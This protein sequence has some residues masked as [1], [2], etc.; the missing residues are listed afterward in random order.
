MDLMSYSN[1]QAIEQAKPLAEKLRPK[2]LNDLQGVQRLFQRNPWMKSFLEKKYLP[3]IILWG[4]P[5]TGKT[6]LALILAENSGQ[7]LISVNAVETGAKELKQ[8]G[9][10]CRE[11]LK[12]KG[13]RSV[14]FIDEIHRLN[15]SQQD[16]LLPFVEKGE[17]TLIGATTEN[18]SY[19]INR[20]LLSRCRLVVIERLTPADLLQILNQSIQYF[21]EKNHLNFQ[22][23]DSAKAAIVEFADGDA[24]RLLNVLEV[25][26][27]SAAPSITHPTARSAA[28]SAPHSAVAKA[29]NLSLDAKILKTSSSAE[30]SSA[31]NDLMIDPDLVHSEISKNEINNT[32]L[33]ESQ[34][35]DDLNEPTPCLVIDLEFVQHLLNDKTLA[36]DKN[37][38]QHYD[39]ISAFIKSLRGSDPDAAMYYFV[40]ML[41]GG[42]DPKFIA[43]RMV[44]FA[45]EDIGNADPRAITVAVSGFDALEKIGLPEAAINLAQVVTYLAT[46]PKSN[47]SYMAL[48]AAQEFVRQSGSQPVPLKLRSSQT[49]EMKNIGYGQGYK[50]PHDFPK[51]YVQNENY[52]PA[53]VSAQKFYE[54]KEAAYEKHI[55]EYLKWLKS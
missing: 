40:R 9:E 47:R 13:R 27:A 52:W 19:E 34:I 6:S 16:V 33:P 23:Q 15:K 39:I 50:Y 35:G 14:L 21:S 10:D 11:K 24:R 37:S 31:D 46:A 22:I 28:P 38:D 30:S 55:L 20:A 41:E 53:E 25:L 1:Q 18:P 3:S 12:Y 45:S 48:R 2:H 29:L 8:I 51:S 4:P 17:V 49:T 44:I 36:Y 42:E 43:R 5:G 32:K 54:P 26:V 7:E